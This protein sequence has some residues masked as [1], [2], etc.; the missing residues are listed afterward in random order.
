MEARI[1]QFSALAL[2][3]FLLDDP[4]S[5][6]RGLPC[7]MLVLFGENDPSR[8]PGDC[9]SG[10][11][12]DTPNQPHRTHVA[13]LPAPVAVVVVVT[14]VTRGNPSRA[15]IG[16]PCPIARPI[17]VA[18]ANGVVIAVDPGVTGTGRHRTSCIVGDNGR[19]S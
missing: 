9:T 1:R 14:V 10:V 4:G 19:R 13:G 18:C 7:P 17:D 15:G 5:D 3:Q 6:F 11:P 12:G 2:R 8:V 16:T